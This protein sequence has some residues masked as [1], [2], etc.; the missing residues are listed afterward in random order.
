MKY[1]NNF[2]QMLTQKL[3]KII[4]SLVMTFLSVV[5][6]GLGYPLTAI[7]LVLVAILNKEFMEV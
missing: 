2:R 7:W 4:Y 6:L 5:A 1:K 3:G